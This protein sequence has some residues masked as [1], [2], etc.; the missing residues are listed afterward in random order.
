MLRPHRNISHTGRT[1]N[2]AVNT[3]L[4][5]KTKFVEASLSSAK[6]RSLLLIYGEEKTK[7]KTPWS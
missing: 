2:A 1:G 4:I 7:M 5:K 6:H 3:F